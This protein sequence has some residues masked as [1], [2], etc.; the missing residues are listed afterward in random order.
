[1][2]HRRILRTAWERAFDMNR[3]L[4]NW[5]GLKRL[6]LRN[7]CPPLMQDITQR[8]SELNVPGTSAGHE[9]ARCYRGDRLPLGHPTR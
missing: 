5:D 7:T 2:A 6:K 4:T 3:P 1:M 9:N 8:Y